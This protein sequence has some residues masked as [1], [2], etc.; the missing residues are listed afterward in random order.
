MAEI[1]P[2]SDRCPSPWDRWLDGVERI[3]GAPILGIK[4]GSERLDH[5][6]DI[7]LLGGTVVEGVDAMRRL[8]LAVYSKRDRA[9]YLAIILILLGLTGAGAWLFLQA[10]NHMVS[11]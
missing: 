4:G 1:V 9:I 5:L 7:Y 6:Y 8:D 10:L 3:Y 11:Q 2:F